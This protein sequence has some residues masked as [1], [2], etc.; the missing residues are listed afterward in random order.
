MVTSETALLLATAVHAGFQLTVTLVVYP[1][2]ARVS[3]AQ[4]KETHD[5]HTRAITPLVVVVY[6]LLVLAGVW[7]VIDGPDAW[8]LVALASAAVALLVTGSSAGPTHRRLGA[9]HDPGRI[10]GLLRADRIRAVA[11]VIAVIAAT[12]AV[13]P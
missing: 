1:A 4:W 12:M 9:G 13:H 2:L 11:A 6:G 8:T 7:A 10:R 3:P 5:A